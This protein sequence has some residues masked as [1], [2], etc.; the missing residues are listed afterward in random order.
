MKISAL[1]IPD[2]KKIQ[3]Q[4]FHD[5]RGCFFE[6]FN[7]KKLS[8]ALGKKISFIQDNQSFS[9]KAVLRGLHYQVV[10]PQA[11]LVS[12]ISGT[13]F[14]VAVDLRKNSPSFGQWI[15]E[16][17]SAENKYQL[18]IPEGFAHGFLVLSDGATFQYKVSNEW[19]PKHERCI[20]FDDK[21]LNIQ[22]P[23]IDGGHL[24]YCLS[25]KDKQGQSFL[26]AEVYE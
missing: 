1:K 4:V 22:W 26:S 20:V 2:V 17:L 13:V 6:Q 24:N 16:I 3:P 5:E 12:V 9:K 14:D 18:F 21:D 7:A 11:K 10:E 19:Y 8:E 25:E 23:E 15:G